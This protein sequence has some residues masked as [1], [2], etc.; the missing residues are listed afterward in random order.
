MIIVRKNC[1]PPHPAG[2]VSPTFVP[3]PSA[4]TATCGIAGGIPI[5]M[6]VLGSGRASAMRA[7]A[8]FHTLLSDEMPREQVEAAESVLVSLQ[9]VPRLCN[10][11]PPDIPGWTGDEKQGEATALLSH[12]LPCPALPCPALPCPSSPCPALPCHMTLGSATACAIEHAV[13]RCELAHGI[14]V[15]CFVCTIHTVCSSVQMCRRMSGF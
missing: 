13:L 15:L 6:L 11:L 2:T 12:A 8:V 3:S 4:L 5:M 14:A 10:L 1:P 9:A 7:F